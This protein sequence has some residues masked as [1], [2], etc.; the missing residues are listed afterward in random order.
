M[1]I[2]ADMWADS[3]DQCSIMDHN[4]FIAKSLGVTME[5]WMLLRGEIMYD[6]DPLLVKKG[7]R[8]Y[9]VRLNREAIKQRKY[10]EQQSKNG[11]SGSKKRWK[12]GYGIAMVSLSPG[13]GEGIAKGVAKNSSSSS[14]SPDPDPDPEKM[15]KK[16]REEKIIK[17][18]SALKDCA[19]PSNGTMTWAS[20]AEAYR[21]RYE[22]DPVRNAKVNSR[23]K[24]LVERLG[25]T[26]A[27]IV[28][29][30]YVSL[31]DP[32]YLKTRHSVDILVRD[33]EAL[34]TRF[35]TKDSS[36]SP[37]TSMIEYLARQFPEAREEGG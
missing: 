35:M 14:S 23:M 28:A 10:S 29:A 8:L 11:M 22:V 16:K 1:A 26:D 4:P 15:K 13:H 5:E 17:N 32:F 19:P 34:H 18:Y 27:P 25:S 24:Q 2:M 12:N 9:S 37:P 31:S 3:K 30:Y 7:E 36:R 20:Y 6:D 21:S 33:C